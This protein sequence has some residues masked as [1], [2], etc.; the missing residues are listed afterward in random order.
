MARPDARAAPAARAARVT[1]RPAPRSAVMRSNTRRI[2]RL[3]LVGGGAI[4]VELPADRIADRARRR[5]V[6]RDSRRADTPCRRRRALRCARDGAGPSRRSDRPSRTSSRVSVCERW[7]LRS[8]LRSMPTSSAPSRRRRAV[9]GARAR[10]CAT[11]T[12]CKPA[13]DAILRAIASASGL[14]Q[15]LP[16]QTNRIFMRHASPIESGH[17]LAQ[18]R[19]GN[20][21]GPDDARRASGAIH[22]RRRLRR[23]RAC[24]RRAP[25]ACRARSRRPTARESRAPTWPAEPPAGSRS[26]R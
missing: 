26:S 8:M 6:R 5:A 13:L 10:R 15:V 18:R 17:A 22:D 4:D 25:A 21:A 7:P 12:S 19:G 1:T 24:R 2:S 20:R 9:P 14:R 16:V 11:S 3:E 23:R